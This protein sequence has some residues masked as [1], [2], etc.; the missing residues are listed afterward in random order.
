MIKAINKNIS[1]NRL[2]KCGLSYAE[3]I[4][5]IHL[6]T[7]WLNDYF[8]MEEALNELNIWINKK[9]KVKHMLDDDNNFCNYMD[10]D[11]NMDDESFVARRLIHYTRYITS[12]SIL[13]LGSSKNLSL[14]RKSR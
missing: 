8:T 2:S 13:N 4:K 5:V 14:I 12:R 10:N 1:L 9:I 3:H 7:G 6:N 11:I